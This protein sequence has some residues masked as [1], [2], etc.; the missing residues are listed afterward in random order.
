MSRMILNLTPDSDANQSRADARVVT[1]DLVP[2]RPGLAQRIAATWRQWRQN[3]RDRRALAA[4]T[5]RALR[6]IGLSEG[7]VEFELSR[8][9]WRRP[10]DLRF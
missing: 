9:F 2:V 5:P 1:I 7:L 8:P 4:M 3:V 6:D 10:R